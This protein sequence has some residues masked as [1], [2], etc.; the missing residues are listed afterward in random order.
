[1]GMMEIYGVR[2]FLSDDG[3]SWGGFDRVLL[4][5]VNEGG[6]QRARER[7]G[8]IETIN[9]ISWNR[10]ECFGEMSLLSIP[11][12]ISRMRASAQHT[13]HLIKAYTDRCVWGL[14]RERGH[15]LFL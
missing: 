4:H 1:M 14:S 13:L 7:C 5:L 9:W 3:E 15:L 2:G 6:R 10:F 8:M 11:F 12:S